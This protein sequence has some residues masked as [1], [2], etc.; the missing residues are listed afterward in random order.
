ML[1][2]K[3]CEVRDWTKDWKCFKCVE[4]QCIMFLTCLTTISKS[5]KTWRYLTSSLISLY[6]PYTNAS[7]SAIL[8]VH[9]NSNLQV[10]IVF[11]PSRLINMQPSPS[12]SL[13]FNASKYNVQNK[14][15]TNGFSNIF[16][17]LEKFVCKK[18][19]IWEVRQL[20]RN[21]DIWALKFSKNYSVE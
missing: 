14:E 17:H 13:D 16:T 21:G 15:L 20:L 5:P 12:P 10:N 18:I 4:I 6:I 8:S 3:K 19:S 9:L 1:N 11:T 7:Y 2:A